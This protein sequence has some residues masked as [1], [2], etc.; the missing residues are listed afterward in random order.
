VPLFQGVE[1]LEPGLTVGAEVGVCV[2]FGVG[3]GAE[4]GVDVGEAVGVCVAFGVGESV[5]AEVPVGT[6]VGA[7]EAVGAGVGV[8]PRGVAVG[9]GDALGVEVAAAVAAEVGDA[10]GAEEG[11]AVAP[12]VSEGRLPTPPAPEQA[13]SNAV[14]P[15]ATSEIRVFTIALRS[16][17]QRGYDAKH[18]RN[19]SSMRAQHFPSRKPLEI[20]FH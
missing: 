13:H 3:D 12:P 8:A 16:P 5:G 17:R 10:V 7:D 6:A 2:A 11:V 9:L 1:Q 15:K 20:I 18:T 4:V 19:E 14:S